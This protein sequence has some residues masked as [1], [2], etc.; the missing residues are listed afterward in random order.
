M[1]PLRHRIDGVMTMKHVLPRIRSRKLS[2]QPSRDGVLLLDGEIRYPRIAAAQAPNAGSQMSARCHL[3]AVEYLLFLQSQGYDAAQTVWK[4]KGPLPLSARQGFSVTYLGLERMSLVFQRTESWQSGPQQLGR[5]FCLRTGRLLALHDL[6]TGRYADSIYEY[7]LD[8]IQ[9]EESSYYENYKVNARKHLQ[10][11]NYFLTPQ[12]VAL[13][14]PPDTIAPEEK[15][16]LHF[17]IPY[18]LLEEYQ[19]PRQMEEE[20]VSYT[21]LDGESVRP[22]PKN[23]PGSSPYPG[24]RA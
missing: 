8:E 18:S 10:E 2:Y 15:G 3:D 9:R 22:T 4:Q 20:P 7:I 13:F 11:E 5:T 19:I 14:Y 1:L 12:G 24:S 21:H 17:T 23:P 16:V 6:Y